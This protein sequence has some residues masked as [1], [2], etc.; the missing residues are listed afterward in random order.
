MSIMT[1][2]ENAARTTPPDAALAT[3]SMRSVRTASVPP[4]RA[5]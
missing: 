2:R 4:S 3:W 1:V 5:S